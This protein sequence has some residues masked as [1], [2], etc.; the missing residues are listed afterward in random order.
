MIA[1]N[2][3]PRVSLL[4]SIEELQESV[5]SSSSLATCD[6]S[7]NYFVEEFIEITRASRGTFKFHVYM[8]HCMI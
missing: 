2:D 5:T 4:V 3:L 8:F 1:N 7:M 6:S